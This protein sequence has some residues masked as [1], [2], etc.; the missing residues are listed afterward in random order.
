MRIYIDVHPNCLTDSLVPDPQTRPPNTTKQRHS[1]GSLL[2]A[3]GIAGALG[4]WAATPADVVKTRLQLAG[5]KEKYGDMG[6]CFRTILKEEGPS[7][8]FKG[9]LGVVV[10]MSGVCL[11]DFR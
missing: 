9:A 5:G 1:I 2:G 7:A 10:C 8:L 11:I 6:N 3:G 4:A